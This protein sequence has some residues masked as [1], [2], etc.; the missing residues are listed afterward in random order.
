MRFT[1]EFI[2]K[3]KNSNLRCHFAVAFGV[4]Y[5][6]ICDW[7]EKPNADELTKP[8]YLEHIVRLTGFNSEEI[9]EKQDIKI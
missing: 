5:F 8:K 4:S 9:F 7:L 1:K 6:T 2:K 3:T